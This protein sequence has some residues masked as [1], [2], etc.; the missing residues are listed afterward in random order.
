MEEEINMK[1][2]SIVESAT[3]ATLEADINTEL[4]TLTT[5]APGNQSLIISEIK[6]SA[7]VNALATDAYMALI[8]YSYL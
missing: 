8:I 7:F 3:A 2:V 6:H 1:Q 5:N 4:D